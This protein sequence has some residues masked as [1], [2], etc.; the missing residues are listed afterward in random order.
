MKIIKGPIRKAIG[1]GDPIQRVNYL[2]HCTLCMRTE[3]WKEEQEKYITR[4]VEKY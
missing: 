2:V 3:R 1:N 4:S